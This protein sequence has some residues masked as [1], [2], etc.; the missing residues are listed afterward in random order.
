VPDP[1]VCRRCGAQFEAGQEY[2][3]ECG[4]RLVAAR[5][6]P[7]LAAWIVPSALALLVAA[8]GAAAAIAARGTPRH[9]SQVAAVA[10]SPLRPAAPRPVV[11]LPAVP[12]KPSGQGLIAWPSTNGYTIVLASLPLSQGGNAARARASAALRDGLDHVGVLVSS[13]YASL[14]PGYYVVFS[15][16]YPSLADAQADLTSA[17]DHFPAAY[18]RPIVR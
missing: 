3:L 14:Q 4:S 8:A 18:A 17:K 5:R 7:G 15:G 6:A 1:L 12:K 9:R 10:V 2:C 11:K 13:S 16:V